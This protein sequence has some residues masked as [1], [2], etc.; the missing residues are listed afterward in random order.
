MQPSRG[1][2][3]QISSHIYVPED[4]EEQTSPDPNSK[5]KFSSHECKQDIFYESMG[6]N[7]GPREQQQFSSSKGGENVVIQESNDDDFDE[8]EFKSCN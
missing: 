5:V 6:L 1:S 2:H 7:K 3:P 4:Y 8:D